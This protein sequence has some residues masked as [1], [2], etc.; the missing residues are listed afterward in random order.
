MR[1]D[2]GGPQP[3]DFSPAVSAVPLPGGGRASGSP[4][5]APGALSPVAAA[6]AAYQGADPGA[7]SA[8]AVPNQP[9]PGAPGLDVRTSAKG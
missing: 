8:G 1:Q 6:R 9:A 5:G 2:E 4:Q 7:A 3:G